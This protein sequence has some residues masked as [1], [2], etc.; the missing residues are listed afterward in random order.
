MW[1]VEYYPAQ[2]TYLPDKVRQKA[3]EVA[4]DLLDQG[5]RYEVAVPT[6]IWTALDWGKDHKK[7]VLN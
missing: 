2:M 5:L 3:I 4:N 7:E 6:A 1:S